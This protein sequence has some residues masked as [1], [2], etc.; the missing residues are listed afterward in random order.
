MMPK[1]AIPFTRFQ[2]HQVEDSF[3]P[4]PNSDER[5]LNMGVL[6]MTDSIQPIISELQKKGHKVEIVSEIARPVMVYIDQESGDM[7]AAGEPGFKY[8]AAINNPDPS[9]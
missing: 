5:I 3:N 1:E 8:C 2:T 4:S 7:F 9:P 6:G